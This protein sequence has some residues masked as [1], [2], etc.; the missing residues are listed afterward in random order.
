MVNPI[1]QPPGAFQTFRLL[2]FKKLPIRDTDPRDGRIAIR[3]EGT[4]TI[5]LDVF[6]GHDQTVTIQ[7]CGSSGGYVG[8]TPL[9]TPQLVP[10]NRS[11]YIT[12]D[13]SQ[14][15]PAY[16][17]VIARYGVAPTDGTLTVYSHTTKFVGS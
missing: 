13:L 9:G 6:N 11:E 12:V 10:A 2:F 15:K 1:V 3:M 14:L 8:A 17:G 5:A 16:V 7:F 4:E